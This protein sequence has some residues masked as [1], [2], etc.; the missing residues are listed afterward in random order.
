MDRS[1][2]IGIGRDN[3]NIFHVS[4]YKIWI[5]N[6]GVKLR[7]HLKKGNSNQSINIYQLLY[8]TAYHFKQLLMQSIMEDINHKIIHIL[9]FLPSCKFSP[10]CWSIHRISGSTPFS[11][12]LVTICVTSMPYVKHLKMKHSFPLKHDLLSSIIMLSAYT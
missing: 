4:F 8:A 5:L 10:P 3:K 7:L 9:S 6:W 11:T 2:K 1:K 12:F